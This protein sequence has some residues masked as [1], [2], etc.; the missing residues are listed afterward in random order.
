MGYE[1]PNY[2]VSIFASDDD[3]TIEVSNQFYG[4]D[5]GPA[6]HIV[7]TDF[8]NGAVVYPKAGGRIF[9]VLQNNP[10][11]GEACEMTCEGISKIYCTGEFAMGDDLAVD[12]QG[13]FVKASG[14]AKIVAIACESG[15]VGEISSGRLV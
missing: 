3:R 11:Q 5:I 4:V 1:Q 15:K 12:A 13:G 8:G 6:K 7:G 9:G 10:L 2:K 14:S